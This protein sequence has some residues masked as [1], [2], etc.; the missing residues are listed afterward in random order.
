MLSVM[1]LRTL[2]RACG[3]LLVGSL[4]V[5]AADLARA[6]D[7]RM[8]PAGSKL[9]YIATLQKARVS[10]TFRQFDA[11]V[12]FD[13]DRLADSQVDVT[14]AMTSAD[15]IDADVNKA[16]RGADWFDSA[17][18]PQAVFHTNDIRKTG[19]NGYLAR[20]TLT[21]KGVEQQIEVPVVWTNEAD[22]ATITGEF[23]LKR[24]TFR[25]G[26][27]E[28]AATDVVAPDVAVKFSVK[29]RRAS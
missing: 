7:W 9:E 15:M 18:F 29:L 12:R 8:D 14:V 28:W 6:A 19:E 16:I 4:L 26:L 17:R 13:A 25:I 21:V 2:L 27:G 24:A 11:R 1:G 10:G 3:L 5:C 20:G 23:T 22:T